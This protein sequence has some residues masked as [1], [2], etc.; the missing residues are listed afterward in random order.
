MRSSRSPFAL[1]MYETNK[2]RA[3]SAAGR[4]LAAAQ[5][6]DDA[7]KAAAGEK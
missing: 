3:K 6:M 1:I 5:E 2:R 4:E 7:G